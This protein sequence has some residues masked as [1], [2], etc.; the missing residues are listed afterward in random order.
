VAEI[1]TSTSDV[2]LQCPA[3]LGDAVGKTQCLKTII[4]V[5]QSGDFNYPQEIEVV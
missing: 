1:A 3:N 5:C 2:A 4:F